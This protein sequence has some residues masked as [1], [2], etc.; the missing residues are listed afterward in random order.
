MDKSHDAVLG[1]WN[2]G[3]KEESTEVQ[4]RRSTVLWWR[5]VRGHWKHL[6]IPPLNLLTLP[7]RS[8]I[9]HLPVPSALLTGQSSLYKEENSPG[10]RRCV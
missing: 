5:S 6:V 4:H 2:R 7:F 9:I 1:S 8:K 10:K 3:R